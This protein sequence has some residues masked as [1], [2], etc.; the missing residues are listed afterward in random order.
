[1]KRSEAASK[2]QVL[3]IKLFNR[4]DMPKNLGDYILYFVENDLKM[5]PPNTCEHGD[6]KKAGCG[7]HWEEE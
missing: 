2:L 7:N 3:L 4:V 5:E 1:M 6:C